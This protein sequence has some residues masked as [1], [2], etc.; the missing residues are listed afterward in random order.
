MDISFNGLNI[1]DLT[2]YWVEEISH[3]APAK[4][5]INLQKIARSNESLLLK[6]TY[7]I[8]TIKAAVVIEDSSIANMDSRMDDFKET[9][10][11]SAK[12]LDIDYAGGTRR[13]VATGYVES[14]DRQNRWA[15]VVVR[16]ECYGAFGTDT[17]ST[18]ES[19]SGKTT[20]PYTDDI[21]IEGNAP[22]KP[23]IT[24]T[25][26][27]VTASGSDQY[28]QLKNTDT[29][30]YVKITR[31]DWAADDVIQIYTNRATVLVNGV[32]NEYLGIMPV[33]DP[34]TNNWEYSD[35]FSARNVDIDFSYNKRW[36]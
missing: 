13:Y 34:G 3:E 31:D 32:V 21:E 4:P 28:I 11:A 14:V 9:M 30:E 2:N 17:A 35:E 7:G 5:E 6:K 33:W 18:D 16:F 10:E 1:N 15:R 27:T 23:D 12:N 22:A 20:S 24:I 29:G 26:N 8:R 19:F 25:I 36:L